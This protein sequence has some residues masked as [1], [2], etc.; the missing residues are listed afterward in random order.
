LWKNCGKS[1]N[2]KRFPDFPQ[3]FPFIYVKNKHD[4]LI[5]E[6]A[7]RCMFYTLFEQRCWKCPANFPANW[8]HTK[9]DYSARKDYIEDGC[10][11]TAD[12][13]FI[14]VGFNESVIHN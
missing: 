5:K 14:H 10:I 2:R 11:E 9:G 6:V 7:L 8:L 1:G 13:V 3:F 4:N 12:K